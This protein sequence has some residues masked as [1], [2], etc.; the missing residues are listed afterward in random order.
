M[1][2]VTIY[3]SQKRDKH[4]WGYYVINWYS[5]YMIQV[6]KL[7]KRWLNQNNFI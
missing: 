7:R 5:K 6:D 1:E 3:E 4:N 2:S